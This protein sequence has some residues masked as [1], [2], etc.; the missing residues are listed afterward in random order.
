MY[1]TNRSITIR[2]L[3]IILIVAITVPMGVS[4]AE[5]I[6]P[7]GS[8]YLISYNAYIYPAGNGLIQA[9][10]TVNGTDYM[11]TIGALTIQIY[12]SKDQVSWTWKK[13]FTHDSTSG[14][15]DHND[16]YHSGHVDYQ[17]IAGRY[18]KAYVCIWAG[19]DG[20]GDSRYFYT[21]SKRAS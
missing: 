19:R 20:G 8:D 18:Y 13:S 1:K 10:F 16:Y 9:W 14:M 15:I 6:Q 11:E 3:A 17:G 5:P 4:A 21:S 12:E 2:V 7:R